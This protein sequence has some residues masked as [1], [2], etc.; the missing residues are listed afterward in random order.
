MADRNRGMIRSITRHPVFALALGGVLG[1]LL[2]TYAVGAVTGESVWDAINWGALEAD[3]LAAMQRAR[4]RESL[5]LA[6]TFGGFAGAVIGGAL[7]LAFTSRPVPS[8]LVVASWWLLACSRS[9]PCL[10]ICPSAGTGRGV[11]AWRC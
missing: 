7:W 3:D 6:A 1:G 8:M 2:S 11:P 5:F 9:R 4:L 10:A